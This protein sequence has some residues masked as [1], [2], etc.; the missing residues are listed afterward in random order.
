MLYSIM[1]VGSTIPISAFEYNIFSTSA[2][3]IRF[4][5]GI[6]T[7]FFSED[8]S[9]GFLLWLITISIIISRWMNSFNIKKILIGKKGITDVSRLGRS[10]ATLFLSPSNYYFIDFIQT[11]SGWHILLDAVIFYVVGFILHDFIVSF[12]GKILTST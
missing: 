10:V 3:R 12:F 2:T 11:S 7:A 9:D 8:K 1:D 6:H 5:G 4:E